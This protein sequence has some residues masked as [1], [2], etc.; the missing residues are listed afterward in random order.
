MGVQI[1]GNASIVPTLKKYTGPKKRTW[2]RLGQSAKHQCPIEDTFTGIAIDGRLE[3]F[4]KALVAI[5]D[6]CEDRENP[7]LVKRIQ[8]AKADLSITVTLSGISILPRLLHP[9]NACLLIT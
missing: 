6:S 1:S 3:Q 8:S 9:R 2:R 4:W 5:L 7:A